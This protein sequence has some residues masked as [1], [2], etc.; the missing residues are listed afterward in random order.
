MKGQVPEKS[1]ETK[2]DLRYGFLMN[3]EDLRNVMHKAIISSP[4]ALGR[5]LGRN[6]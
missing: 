2:D 6:L 5:I 1:S 4:T 3:S